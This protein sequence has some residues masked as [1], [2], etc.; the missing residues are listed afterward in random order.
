MKECS[1]QNPR[2]NRCQ[3][4]QPYWNDSHIIVSFH[5]K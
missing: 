3:S 5:G 2:N 4:W 1:E